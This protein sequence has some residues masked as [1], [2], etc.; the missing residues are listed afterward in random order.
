MGLVHFTDGETDALEREGL[1]V[2]PPPHPLTPRTG[3]LK[4]ILQEGRRDGDQ[5]VF[6]L[7]YSLPNLWTG[8]SRNLL[9]L[10]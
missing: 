10:S 8:V 1:P 2:T 7:L 5:K 3:G 9:T 6:C 4:L